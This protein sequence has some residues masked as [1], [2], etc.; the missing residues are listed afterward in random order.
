MSETTVTVY[1]VR[2]TVRGRVQGVGFRYWAHHTAHQLAG[3]AG[4]VRNLPEGDVEVEAESADREPLEY[5]LR[6]LHHGP[7]TAHVTT[8]DV[9]WEEAVPARQSGPFRVA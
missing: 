4:Y 7:T 2:A 6:E 9:H 3:V 5:L 1:R 8:V